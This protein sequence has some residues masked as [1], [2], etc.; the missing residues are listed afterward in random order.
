M[1]ISWIF[2]S[3]SWILTCLIQDT[4]K[5]F[6][7]QLKD[8]FNVVVAGWCDSSAIST[9]KKNSENNCNNLWANNTVRL[10]VFLL[11]GR[12]DIYWSNLSLQ[13]QYSDKSSD[14]MH[15]NH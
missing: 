3:F 9:V 6:L 7:S 12:I 2:L 1:V 14:K 11:P 15:E 5:F 13:D 4:V 10:T 8:S